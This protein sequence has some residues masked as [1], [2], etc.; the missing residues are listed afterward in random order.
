[1]LLLSIGKNLPAMSKEDYWMI[2]YWVLSRLFYV[3]VKMIFVV[4]LFPIM[5]K[6]FI[7]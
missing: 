6:H 4:N 7:E 5:I 2:I 1:M 3:F